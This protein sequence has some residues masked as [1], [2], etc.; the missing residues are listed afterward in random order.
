M[1]K[2]LDSDDAREKLDEIL[3]NALADGEESVTVWEVKVDLGK[4]IYRIFFSREEL[5]HYIKNLKI[6]HPDTDE[7][8]WPYFIRMYKVVMKEESKSYAWLTK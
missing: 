6:Q 4:T 7:S 3:N 5:D 8:A 1:D 2:D